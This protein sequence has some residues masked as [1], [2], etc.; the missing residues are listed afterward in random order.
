VGGQDIAAATTN[1]PTISSQ[2]ASL[3]VGPQFKKQQ[4]PVIMF[5][6]YEVDPS[7]YFGYEIDQNV[8]YD[9]TSE[10]DWG[11]RRPTD[12]STGGTEVHHA[13]PPRSGEGGNLPPQVGEQDIACSS[14]HN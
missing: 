12:G 13:T 10:C 2:S 8:L 9:T 4:R 7:L 3:T 14:N 5:N 11:W 6:K 1:N